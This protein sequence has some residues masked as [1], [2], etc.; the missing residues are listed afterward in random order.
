M[1][2][3]ASLKKAR[4]HAFKARE[5]KA[6]SKGG[7]DLGDCLTRTIRTIEANQPGPIYNPC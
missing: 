5:V 1:V 6:K 3:V 7:E 4:A 2:Q